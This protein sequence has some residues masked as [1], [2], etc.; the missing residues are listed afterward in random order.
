MS[1]GPRGSGGSDRPRPSLCQVVTQSEDEQSIEH[2]ERP[3]PTRVELRVGEQRLQEDE[4]DEPHREGDDGSPHTTDDRGDEHQDRYEVQDEEAPHPVRLHALSSQDP[5]AGEEELDRNG[6]DEQPGKPD[7]ELA[8]YVHRMGPPQ[9]E[10]AGRR[11]SD[12]PTEPSQARTLIS[13][14]EIAYVLVVMA[15]SLD[16]LPI[17]ASHAWSR[18]RDE[19]RR[20][21]GDDL[22]ALWGYGGTIFPDR[23]RRL[24]D[25]DTFAVLELVPDERT[26]GELEWAEAEISREHGIDWDIWYVLVA[27]ARRSE[28]PP[29][30]LDPERRHASWAIDRAHWHAGR[31]INLSGR[32]P[33]GSVPA[34]TWQEI[35]ASLRHELEHLEQHVED[36]DDDPFEATY[37]IWNGSRILYAI[38][39]RDVVISKRSGGMWALEHLPQRWHE[40]IRAAGRA[41][42][43]EAT[44]RDAEVLR[45]TMA[46]FV[47]MVR[48]PLSLADP[49]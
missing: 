5:E 13:R 10:W 7:E 3:E 19:V 14:H 46:A 30:A 34:P 6:E 33:E 15:A 18:L 4:Q 32:A 29:H 38:E 47:A 43:G 36:G 20:A 35:E 40:A 22:T 8:P 9:I 42:D 31:Y 16:E 28:P 49:R 44:P 25:L 26:R 2:V 27:D 23:S 45:D 1:H 41:Y 21:L 12:R 37:A 48:E 17:A 24:G 11:H 39:T